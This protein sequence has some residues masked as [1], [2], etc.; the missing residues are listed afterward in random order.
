LPF[1]SR[2]IHPGLLAEMPKDLALRKEQL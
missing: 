2:K 1:L